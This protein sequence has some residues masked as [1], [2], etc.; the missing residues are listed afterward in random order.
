VLHHDNAVARIQ[1]A[2]SIDDRCAS[3]ATTARRDTRAGRYFMEYRRLPILI[4]A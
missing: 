3:L 4:E 2:R 1:V